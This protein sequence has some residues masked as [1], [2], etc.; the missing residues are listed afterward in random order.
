MYSFQNV[1]AGLA[2]GAGFPSESYLRESKRVW[3]ANVL[4][5]F[6]TVF[7]RTVCNFDYVWESQIGTESAKKQY[8]SNC[9]Q[10]VFKIY[11]SPSIG[12]KSFKI[13]QSKIIFIYFLEIFSPQG[14]ICCNQASSAKWIKSE[15]MQQ[16]FDIDVK[17]NLRLSHFRS[18]D[19]IA[20]VQYE[21]TQRKMQK[22][23]KAWNWL[24]GDADQ[25][26]KYRL[27]H[28]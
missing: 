27:S 7:S 25:K 22:S 21:S 26:V 14:N 23:Q 17:V 16:N 4:I 1:Q 12:C 19:K 11:I 24:G 18:P 2:W 3:Q 6:Q 15:K 8:K 9:S 20:L 28:F 10:A 5:M 13:L